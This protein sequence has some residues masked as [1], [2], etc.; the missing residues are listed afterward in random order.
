MQ[1]IESIVLARNENA[2]CCVTRLMRFLLV[3]SL[4]VAPAYCQLFSFGAKVGVP[5]TSAF[6]NQFIADGGSSTSDQHYIIGATAEVH[7]FPHLSLEADALYRRND[8]FFNGALLNPTNYTLSNW[9]VPIL[10]K[11]EIG[12]IKIAKPFIDGGLTYRHLTSGGGSATLN[13]NDA[14][15]TFGGGVDLKLLLI[16]ISPEIRYTNWR[17]TASTTAGVSTPN[18]ADL[19]VGF[20]F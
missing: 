19:L 14:G 20:T 10:A 6:N 7:F 2:R 1:E 17:Q 4:A 13:P 8:F 5:L 3:L 9:Q 11:F 16:H 15:I 18:Q 12:G